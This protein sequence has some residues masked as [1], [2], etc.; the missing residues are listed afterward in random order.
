MRVWVVIYYIVR[1]WVVILYY[2][3]R[4]MVV[5]WLDL[6]SIISRRIISMQYIIYSCIDTERRQVHD[7]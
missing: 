2:I 7:D 1:V 4:V 3:V 5:L 6:N